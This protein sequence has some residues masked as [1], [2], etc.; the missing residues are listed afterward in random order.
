MAAMLGTNDP[1]RARPAA[2]ALGMAMQRTNIL[3]D[4]DED[5]RAGRIYLA[6]ETIERH[7]ALAPGRRAA[8][9]REQIAPRGRAVRAGRRRDR[10][11][12]HG[13]RAVAA[14]AAMYRAILRQIERAGYAGVPGRAIV[15][16][17]RKLTLGLLAALRA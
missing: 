12:R 9:L 2:I 11:A 17:R 15:P 16:R 4:I 3:R 13:R 5:A 14:A 6:R 7:G 1:E 8:L 10:A